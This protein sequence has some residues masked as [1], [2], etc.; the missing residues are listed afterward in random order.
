MCSEGTRTISL[1]YFIR[2]GC[3][4]GR[5]LVDLVRAGHGRKGKVACGW[6]VLEYCKQREVHSNALGQQT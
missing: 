5:G 3:R 2:G 6:G 4:D 1:L